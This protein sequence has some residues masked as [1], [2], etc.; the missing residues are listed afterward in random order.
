MLRMQSCTT[1]FLNTTIQGLIK[2]NERL[3]ERIQELKKRFGISIK[4]KTIM[5]K[6]YDLKTLIFMAGSVLVAEY[7]KVP[8][9]NLARRKETRR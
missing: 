1:K 3:R 6:I 7:T 8:R 2:D 4:D 5:L 9:E